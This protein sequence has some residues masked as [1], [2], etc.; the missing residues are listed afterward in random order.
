MNSFLY[1]S[2]PGSADFQSYFEDA[3]YGEFEFTF[4]P[5][6]EKQGKV[7]LKMSLKEEFKLPLLNSGK[8]ENHIYAKEEYLLLIEKAIK[9]I[10]DNNLGKVV[11]SRPKEIPIENFEAK[12]A[13]KILIRKYPDACVYLFGNEKAGTWMG[14]SPETLIKGSGNE[15]S[16][17][18]LAGTKRLGKE[19][20]FGPKEFEEQQLVTDYIRE[21]VEAD[22]S[23]KNLQIEKRE[24]IQAGNLLHLSTKIMATKSST[25]NLDSFLKS[26]HPTPAVGGNPKKEALALIEDLEKHSRSYY[27]GYFGL[28]NKDSFHYFVNLRCMQ[29]FNNSVVLYAGGGIT[30]ESDPNEEWQETESKM[31][32]LLNVLQD[33]L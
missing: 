19:D 27:S 7:C 2:P 15:I 3:N 20:Q 13:F 4:F 32:T 30:S 6:N 16:T 12:S 29:V 31:E 23:L 1:I 18:S 9:A 33:Q 21:I 10:K 24:I 5:F 26:Y 8:T 17:L 14:A 11:I 28:K 22:Q 25:F